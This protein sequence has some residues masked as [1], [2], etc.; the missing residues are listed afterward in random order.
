MTKSV[1]SKLISKGSSGCVFRPQIPCKKHI[2]T[3][4]K[5]KE[6]NYETNDISR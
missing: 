3:K 1:K 6:V 4:K 2:K 5:I